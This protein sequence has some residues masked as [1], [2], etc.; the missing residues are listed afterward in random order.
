M[1]ILIHPQEGGRI[2][3]R[4][5]IRILVAMTVTFLFVVSALSFSGFASAAGKHYRGPWGPVWFDK[6]SYAR[7]ETMSI[8][9]QFYWGTA[10]KGWFEVDL[11]NPSGVTVLR[12]QMYWY[13]SYPDGY[14]DSMTYTIKLGDPTGTWTAEL[15]HNWAGKKQMQ[16]TVLTVTTATVY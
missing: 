2:R 10:Q 13:G 5:R 4:R 8:S 11:K 15:T 7:G 6:D 1:P 14:R 3:D 9:W 12:S 16:T